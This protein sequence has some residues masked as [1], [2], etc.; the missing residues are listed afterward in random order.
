MNTIKV[1]SLANTVVDFL[2]DLDF[3]GSDRAIKLTDA[4]MIPTREQ[5]SQL[6]D[7][8]FAVKIAGR[9][10]TKRAYPIFNK[11]VATLSVMNFMDDSSIFNARDK[12][13]VRNTLK[14]AAQKQG[15]NPE[16]ITE[17]SE[18]SISPVR[19]KKEEELILLAL[20]DDFHKKASITS[21][22]E[23]VTIA[24][25]IKEWAESTGLRVTDGD[26]R[27]YTPKE[28]FGS[29]V[30]VGIDQRTELLAKGDNEAMRSTWDTIKKVAS[31]GDVELFYRTLELFDKH[32]G[33]DS[34]YESGLLN[35]ALTVYGKPTTYKDMPAPEQSGS[36]THPSRDKLAKAIKDPTKYNHSASTKYTELTAK[37]Y[38]AGK[39]GYRVNSDFQD[40]HE[41]PVGKQKD[42]IK[43]RLLY[44]LTRAV[45]E[46]SF[47]SKQEYFLFLNDPVGYY[48]RCPKDTKKML[49]GFLEHRV[50]DRIKYNNVGNY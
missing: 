47:N 4:K 22:S 36:I 10:G 17:L 12:E 39:T 41:T 33:I 50:K 28:K 13:T 44:E 25:K 16:L 7:R 24:Q 20:Q 3:L 6:P 27:N 34:R 23:K 9:L 19:E 18:G 30:Y 35:P 14:I 43:R 15:V 49:D 40:L 31:V 38:N 29:N 48:R 32:A 2:D 5:A 46:G 45:G 8:A 26:V 1:A 37:G 21:Y 42:A 11:A